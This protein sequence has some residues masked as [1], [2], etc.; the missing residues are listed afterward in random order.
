MNEINEYNDINSNDKNSEFWIDKFIWSCQVG[1]YELAQ[2]IFY[3]QFPE[4]DLINKIISSYNLII[5]RTIHSTVRNFNKGDH[6]KIIKWIF[7]LLQEN[8]AVEIYETLFSGIIEECC[9]FDKLELIIWL[10][11]KNVRIPIRDCLLTSIKNNRV[12]IFNWFC[13]NFVI[14]DIHI[15]NCLHYLFIDKK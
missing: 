1:D 6:F 8:D 3:H 13:E 2:I 14:N 10:Q 12:A 15:I 4:F 11:S 7:E 5:E 9:E